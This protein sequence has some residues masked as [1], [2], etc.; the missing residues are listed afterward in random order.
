MSVLFMPGVLTFGGCSKNQA[1]GSL[2]EPPPP[3]PG[4]QTTVTAPHTN[5]PEL[6]AVAPASTVVVT[7]APGGR[8]LYLLGSDGFALSEQKVDE[9]WAGA[10][11]DQINRHPEVRKSLEDQRGA[12][13]PGDLTAEDVA[14]IGHAMKSAAE[15][16]EFKLS[17]FSEGGIEFFAHFA[18]VNLQG[19]IS[20]DA[21]RVSLIRIP[22]RKWIF[23]EIVAAG[24]GPGL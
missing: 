12:A 6:E 22:P 16:R 14:A 20:N 17:R 21:V 19:S 15:L 8:R 11:A 13:D 18:I 3:S 1:A 4:P 23:G 2:S 9:F 10:A 7:N 24:G 5:Q